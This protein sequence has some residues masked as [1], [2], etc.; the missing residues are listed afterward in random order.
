VG[1]ARNRAECETFLA[2]YLARCGR[3]GAK[4]EWIPAWKDAGAIARQL[5]DEAV[6]WAAEHELRGKALAEVESLA[7]TEILETALNQLSEA[8][9]EGVRPN[10][11]DEELARAASG[12]ALWTASGAVTWAIAEERLGSEDDPFAPKL[13]IFEL[14]HWPLGMRS[15]S[16]A[17][18]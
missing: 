1:T 2:H 6:L 15:G 16:Y 10:Y 7:R 8:G 18:F 17:I 9:Y 3:P 11:P 13:R 4:A 12:A 5:D 14:G